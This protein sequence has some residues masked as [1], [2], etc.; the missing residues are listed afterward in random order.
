VRRKIWRGLKL[1]LLAICLA[2]LVAAFVF[3]SWVGA[4]A[5][6]VTVLSTAIDTP[7]LSWFVRLVTPDPE[8]EEKTVGGM[9]ATL[10]RPGGSGPWSAIVFVNGAT[11]RGRHHPDVQR[12]ARGLARAGYLTVVPD[13][14]G[15]P[16]GEISAETV[17]A[18]VDVAA[19]TAG[20][21]ARVTA[22]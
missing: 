17:D 4:Q 14:P 2:A 9:P 16:A 10:V 8:V 11:R 12:L 13:L 1:G 20:V 3:S 22:A 18:T 6:A 19:A 5:R 15:L 21:P 7:V